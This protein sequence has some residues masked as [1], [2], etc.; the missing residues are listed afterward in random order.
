[1]A[2]IFGE[3]SI[4]SPLAN[5]LLT[6]LTAISLILG[7]V[8]F[9]FSYLGTFVP[10]LAFLSKWIAQILYSVS[11]GML[12]ITQKMSDTPGALVSL[13]YGFVQVLLILLICALLLFLLLKWKKPRRFFYVIAAWAAIF[14]ICLTVTKNMT[15]GQ[16][17]ATYLSDKM[18][19]L[20][21][22]SNNEVT[23]L[24]DITD[25]SY[26]TYRDFL[27]EGKPDTT[28]EID[29]LILT[30]YHNRHISTVYKLL[31]DIRVRTIWLPLTMTYTDQDKAIKDEGNLRSIVALAKQRRVEVRYY[32]P[33]ESA[34]ITDTLTLERLYFSML[35]RSTHPTVSFTFNYRSQPQEEGKCLTWLGASA[36]E[37]DSADE[38]L[39][40]A[41]ASD[42]MIFSKHGPVIKT[43]YSLIDWSNIPD[44]VL[45]SDGNTAAAL[46][47]SKEMSIVLE[48]AR[49]LLGEEYAQMDL[50]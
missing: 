38:L 28:T 43:T 35:K 10:F 21:C 50:P 45:F 37:G 29:A 33:D 26:T 4:M 47:A 23:V 32:L 9:P 7:L 30:H 17:Q 27:S 1:M 12:K 34:D 6:P 39:L 18:N 2:L 24:C 31:G 36:W 14:V 19:E 49:V 3:V 22:L 40:A 41:T 15:A 42:V 11:D 13:R 5:L 25:G 8:Y 16:W 44:I 48:R 20:F 46:E